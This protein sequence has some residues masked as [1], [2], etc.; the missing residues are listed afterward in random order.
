MISGATG[1]GGGAG[2]AGDMRSPGGLMGRDEFLQLLV[3]QLRHQDPLN[4]MQ[5][6]EFASHLAQFSQVE[7][8]IQLN[9]QTEI[10]LEATGQL[11]TN[12]QDATAMGT[13]GRE[14][15]ALGNRFQVGEGSVP[16]LTAGI[17]GTGGDAVVRIFDESGKEVATKELGFLAPGR[18]DLSVDDLV[19]GLEEG[20]YTFKLQV[21]S[22]TGEAVEA[23]TLTRVRVEG[24]R[25][26]PK[27]PI[28]MAGGEEIP[29][30]NVLEVL[31]GKP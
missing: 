27:G 21:T 13:L 16:G 5:A 28:L 6:E 26:G 1:L 14:V 29:L 20:R 11:I 25:Y 31:A 7:Q 19:S 9:E 17:G 22:E 15:L 24:I 2:A 3:A 12:Y 18:H 4:P 30:G 23:Q 10:G 8:L